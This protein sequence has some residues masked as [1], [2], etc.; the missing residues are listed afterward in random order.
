MPSCRKTVSLLIYINPNR[1]SV[2]PTTALRMTLYRIGNV[3][4]DDADH[5]HSCNMFFPHTKFFRCRID[6]SAPPESR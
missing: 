3:Q 1:S 6:W 2:A 5:G 4:R